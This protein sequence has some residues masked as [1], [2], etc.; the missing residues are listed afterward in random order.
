M[1]T[2]LPVKDAPMSRAPNPETP[3]AL[4]T[5]ADE[6]AAVV[7]APEVGGAIASYAWNGPRGRIDWFR[8]TPEA[9]VLAR[10]AVEFAC[11]PLVPY[12]NR[13]RD[14]RFSFAGRDIDLGGREG[15]PHSEH[16]YGWRSA[17]EVIALDGRSVT[18][19]YLHQPGAWPWRFS[20]EQR[21]TLSRGALSV[22]LELRNLDGT[23]MPAGMGVHPFFPADSDTRLDASVGGMWETDAEVMPTRHGPVPAETDPNAGL[24]LAAHELD[25]AFTG[26]SGRATISWPT[27]GARLE[28]AADPLLG[29]LVVY[30]PRGAGYFCAEPVSNDT[31]AVNLTSG[32]VADTGL[33]VLAPG[34]ARAAEV[35]F[36]PSL[37]D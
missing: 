2:R 15:D 14:S 13:I 30:T 5:I 9:A 27:R 16:G 8:P 25:T 34:E 17:W 32:E 20:V 11:F 28:M 7:V 35:T 1:A 6:L 22:R 33:F 21:M 12:S 4:V 29:R 23:A 18:L 37:Q 24:V 3:P 26:W 36:S 10:D 31:N 19:R